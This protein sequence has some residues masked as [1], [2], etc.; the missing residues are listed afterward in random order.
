MAGLNNQPMEQQPGTAKKVT[1]F[2]AG[3][4]D[5]AEKPSPF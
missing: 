2:T 4:L 3:S 1:S 5:G